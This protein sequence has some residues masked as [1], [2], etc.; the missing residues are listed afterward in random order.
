VKVPEPFNVSILWGQQKLHEAQL[1]MA[2]MGGF[3]SHSTRCITVSWKQCSLSI[4]PQFRI[5]FFQNSMNFSTYTYKQHT[6][7]AAFSTDVF[8]V[9]ANNVRC[10]AMTIHTHQLTHPC[11]SFLTD[12]SKI[13]RRPTGVASDRGYTTSHI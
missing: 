4:M 12:T 10:S 8:I 3:I 6:D 11:S 9:A 13:S 7:H 1:L 5:R 2:S